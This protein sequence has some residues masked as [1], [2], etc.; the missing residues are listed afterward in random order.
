MN[1]SFE[2]TSIFFKRCIFLWL[3]GIIR[4][5]GVIKMHET[6]DLK[7]FIYLILTVLALVLWA[8]VWSCLLYTSDAADE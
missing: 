3:K 7:I 1:T 8:D 2:K 6:R 4:L 5:K